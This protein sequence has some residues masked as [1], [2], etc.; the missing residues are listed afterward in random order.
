MLMPT[1]PTRRWF[2]F[3]L[4]AIFVTLALAAI[5][6]GWVAYQLDW[7]RQRHAFLER[8]GVVQYPPVAVDRPLPWSLRLFGESQQFLI[9]VPQED[10]E[11]VQQLFPE[12]ILNLVGPPAAPYQ[13]IPHSPLAPTR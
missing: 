5:P 3:S 9:G 1:P 2:R 4:R 8:A 7:I 10:L 12:A 13:S 11:L 6:L